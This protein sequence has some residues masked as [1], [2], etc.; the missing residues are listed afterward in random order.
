MISS[1]RRG[2]GHI[3]RKST[4][5]GS[6]LRVRTGTG[7]TE[8]RGQQEEIMQWAS[9]IQTPASSE[10]D[11]LGSIRSVG[12]A[13]TGTGTTV[14]ADTPSV[15]SERSVS[16]GVVRRERGSASLGVGRKAEPGPGGLLPTP[17]FSLKLAR[18][19]G[20]SGGG[21]GGGGWWK[22]DKGSDGSKG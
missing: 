20:N 22:S 11:G 6:G 19:G 5:S 17:S 3:G 12:T 7:L 2:R 16:P 4:E 13:T 1:R 8:E 18:G 14:G 9:E 15:R 21:G 10:A